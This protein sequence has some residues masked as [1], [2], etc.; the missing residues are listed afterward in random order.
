MSPVTQIL[1]WERAVRGALRRQPSRTEIGPGFRA[2]LGDRARPSR[3]R[4]TAS[5]FRDDYF[6][7]WES[8]D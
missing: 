5:G 8:S 7:R 1:A 4:A 2:R 6:A 3:Q